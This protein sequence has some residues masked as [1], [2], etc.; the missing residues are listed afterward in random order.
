V[1]DD[2]GDDSFVGGDGTDRFELGILPDE[3]DFPD[4]S[5]DIT[6]NA[7]PVLDV[8]AGT[9]TGYGSDTLQGFEH[10]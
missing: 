5:C 4:S 9:V 7:K 2:W 8:T 3:S 6:P 10:Y 1:L